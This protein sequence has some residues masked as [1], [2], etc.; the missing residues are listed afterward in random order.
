MTAALPPSSGSSKARVWPFDWLLRGSRAKA[1]E[2]SL[3]PIADALRARRF[4]EAAALARASVALGA[5]VHGDD[6]AVL[7]A[8]LY[9]LASAE[10]SAEHLDEARAALDRARTCRRGERVLSPPDSQILEM[11]VS[12]EEKRG[13]E[14]DAFEVLLAD[15]VAACEAEPAPP[16]RRARALNVRGVFL[17]RRGR[18][19][20]ARA[21]FERALA[22]RSETF[23]EGHL[24]VLETL[25]N[26]ATYR[27]P[28]REP[29]DAVAA[30]ET[31]VA[32]ARLIDV[33]AARV[34]LASA[35][36]N[37]G[38]LLTELERF[39]EAGAHL[40]EALALREERLGKDAIALRPTVYLLARV[41]QENGK[42]LLAVALYDRAI[43][44]AEKEF[45][46]D[47]E[48]PVLLAL[49]AARRGLVG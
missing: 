15:W 31:V 2:A 22:L 11:C 43:V 19:A 45:A 38:A 46:D 18:L 28:A 20:D 14:S 23:G 27:D 3:D 48:N 17:A 13:E 37:L 5:R 40:E 26:L 42:P 12:V 8:P 6:H 41:A 35:Q 16:E 34:L 30:Y 32:R 33:D 7:R 21:A 29:G 47:D 1:F 44:L 39:E 25:Y 9:A 10:L 4:D 36:H 24:A 49:R